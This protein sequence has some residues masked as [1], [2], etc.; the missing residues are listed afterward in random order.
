MIRK[1]E[2]EAK[3]KLEK[4]NKAANYFAETSNF[5]PLYPFLPHQVASACITLGVDVPSAED[6]KLPE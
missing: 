2:R 5:G 6:Q 3:E 4:F 1:Q